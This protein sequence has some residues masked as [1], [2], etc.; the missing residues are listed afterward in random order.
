[1]CPRPLDAIVSSMIDA[2]PFT[3]TEARQAGLGRSDIRRR[4]LRR[5]GPSTYVSARHIDGVTLKLQTASCRLPDTG[6]FSGFSA[7][8]LHGLDV[9][10]CSPIEVTIPNGQGVSARVGMKVCRARLDVDE[11][12]RMHGLRATTISRTL[13]DLGRRLTLTEATVVTDM[14]LHAGLLNLSIFRVFARTRRGGRGLV[15]LRRVADHAEPKSESPM[16]TRLRML[17]VLAGLPRPVA[18]MSLQDAKGRFLG[19]P[20][21]YY[22]DHRLGIEYDGATHRD[23]LA[24]DNRRQNRLIGQGI[25]LLRFTAADVL[26]NQASVVAQVRALL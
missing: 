20:D 18:Q 17:L 24:A 15:N 25:Q 21:L 12:V 23:S 19:R 8:W 5:V 3:L 13:E 1:L 9:D 4:S 16:E 2:G 22:P 11:V 14:A 6:A 26:H 10:A 7:A